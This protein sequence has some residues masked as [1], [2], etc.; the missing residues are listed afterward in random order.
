MVGE[1][2]LTGAMI[3]GEALN[4]K[5]EENETLSHI[6]RQGSLKIGQAATAVSGFIWGCVEGQDMIEANPDSPYANQG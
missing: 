5:I 2:A 4:E 3:V 6:K 1:K